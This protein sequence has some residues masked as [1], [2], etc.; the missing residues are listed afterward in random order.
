MNFRRW[1]LAA[2]MLAFLGAAVAFVTIFN[3]SEPPREQ[4]LNTEFPLAEMDSLAPGQ[5]GLVI[6]AGNPLFLFRP[7]AEAWSDLEAL[8]QFTNSDIASYNDTYDVFAYW[9]VSTYLGCL[10]LHV[11]K[12]DQDAHEQWLGGYRDPC[13]DV[14]YDYAGRAL[15]GPVQFTRSNQR[16]VADLQV[17]VLGP[18]SAGHARVLK[19][20]SRA[21]N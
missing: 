14:S 7:T 5:Q 8:R 21:S 9:G 1:L 6:V 11:P 17:A 20:F 19:P 15:R 18:A 12:G 4:A 13:H 3:G 10:V 2:A 16:V